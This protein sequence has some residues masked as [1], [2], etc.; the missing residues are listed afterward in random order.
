[1]LHL[2]GGGRRERFYT[3]ENNLARTE[4]VEEARKQ[5]IQTQKAWAPHPRLYVVDNA[6]NGGFEG[7][8]RA[9][10]PAR[11]S[12]GSCATEAHAQVPTQKR[13]AGFG[14]FTEWRADFNIKGNKDVS[15]ARAST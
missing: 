14:V 4:S 12:S 15:Q 11:P 13:P 10:R 9:S 6:G 1:M 2:C 5:D 7:K 8:Q 3:L